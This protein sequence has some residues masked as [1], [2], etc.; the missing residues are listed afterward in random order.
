MC[1]FAVLLS[2]RE[3][4]VAQKSARGSRLCCDPVKVPGSQILF[5]SKLERA[6]KTIPLES[7]F[8]LVQLVCSLK[9]G[10]ENPFFQRI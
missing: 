4:Y 7:G 6:K 1:R 3:T 2:V 5:P 9:T 8:I 10:D